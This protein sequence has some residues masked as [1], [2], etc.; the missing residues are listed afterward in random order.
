MSL[1]FSTFF[2][3]SRV[4]VCVAPL[5]P[6]VAAARFNAFGTGVHVDFATDTNGVALYASLS[7]ENC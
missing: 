5:A 4:C 1:L 2:G 6:A 3:L 7:E